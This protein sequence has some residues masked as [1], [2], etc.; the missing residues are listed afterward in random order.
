MTDKE[1]ELLYYINNF[2]YKNSKVVYIHLKLHS[3][4]Y[5]F[6]QVEVF[7]DEYSNNR[8]ITLNKQTIRDRKLE[9]IL[10]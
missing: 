4:R 2:H 7:W 8:S 3:D 5:N 9:K 6:Y 1:K 10:K